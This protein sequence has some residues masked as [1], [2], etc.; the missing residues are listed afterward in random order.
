MK[1]FQ[2][3][4]FKKPIVKDNEILPEGIFQIRQM[5]HIHDIADIVVNSSYRPKEFVKEIIKDDSGRELGYL[6]LY[7]NVPLASIPDI[8]KL[9]KSFLIHTK[10]EVIKVKP[11]DI[12]TKK[13]EL[14]GEKTTIE[15][16]FKRMGAII[17]DG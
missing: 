8:T 7:C 10:G 4:D 12:K 11:A 14:S 13:Y 1:D 2:D 5:S 6:T 17:P 9:Q 16:L 3:E 15:D